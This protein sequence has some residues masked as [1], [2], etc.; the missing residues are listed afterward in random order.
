MSHNDE[1][2]ILN[3]TPCVTHHKMHRVDSDPRGKR[4]GLVAANMDRLPSVGEKRIA[5]V[6]DLNLVSL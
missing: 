4:L 5:L 6:L 1:S 3:H 2:S